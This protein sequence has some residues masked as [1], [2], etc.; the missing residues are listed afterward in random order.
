MDHTR[1]LPITG[2]FD[3]VS[4]RPG[5]RPTRNSEQPTEG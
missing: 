3:R 2:Y 5:E 1:L 4:A